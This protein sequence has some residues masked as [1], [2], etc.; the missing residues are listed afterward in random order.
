MCSFQTCNN[1]INDNKISYIFYVETSEF[2]WKAKKC[3]FPNFISLLSLIQF[4]STLSLYT[5]IS[6]KKI[7]R[8]LRKIGRLREIKISIYRIETNTV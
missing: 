7:F 4:P 3:I 2:A 1:L 8:V 6:M 5:D